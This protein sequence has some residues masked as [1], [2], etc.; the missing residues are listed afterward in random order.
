MAVYR[1][2]LV[3]KDG[4]TII[5]AIGD[6]YGPVY[7]ASLSSSSGG[8]ATYTFTPDTPV[9]NSRVY[10]VKF[11]APTTNNTIILGDGTTFGSVLVP[12]VAATDT[13]NYELLDTTMINDT[14]PL[15][16]MYNGVQ[17]VC[18]NQKKSVSNGDID[19]TTIP[20]GA[21]GLSYQNFKGYF[22]IGNIRVQY[23]NL[24]KTGLDT[25]QY[26]YNVWWEDWPVSFGNNYYV[27]IAN[28]TSDT[29]NVAGNDLK[30]V[31]R[32]N[33]RVQINYNHVTAIGSGNLYW[34]VIGIGLKPS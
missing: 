15:L 3:D 30:V 21:T 4:N 8:I 23:M 10:A 26:G 17:W 19:W 33:G 1:K 34:G 24:Y 29:G 25:R 32:E 20:Q 2:K 6:I 22:D 31:G 7:T 9:E 12:P 5:P 16:L 28:Q 14:E 18:L 13:P 27:A 11:T